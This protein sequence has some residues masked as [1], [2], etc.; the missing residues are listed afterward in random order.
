MPACP[1]GPTGWCCG[2]RA[3]AAE[4]VAEGRRGRCKG[5]SAARLFQRPAAVEASIASPRPDARRNPSP[6][7]G[8]FLVARSCSVVGPGRGDDVAA[9]A[10]ALLQH[11]RRPG[12]LDLVETC[13]GRGGTPDVSSGVVTRLRVLRDPLQDR[14]ER[15]VGVRS[16]PPAVN[17]P[18]S[19]P[20][21][22]RDGLREIGEGA[23]IAIQGLY[24]LAGR[25]RPGELRLEVGDG[26][27]DAA[28]ALLG[29]W[30]VS[31]TRGIQAVDEHQLGLDVFAGHAART[32]F[33][34]VVGS[35]HARCVAVML[36]WP[37]AVAPRGC[38]WSTMVPIF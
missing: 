38:S 37:Q 19:G 17:G 6:E 32:R 14:P 9:E 5:T 21:G 1:E 27:R 11:V 12:R 28:F 2:R 30:H 7:L 26:D 18:V 35:S 8:G 22:F 23:S 34:G 16:T 3:R 10:V 25:P 13:N 15:A 4:P 20:R 31:G 29:T 33:D 36:H 24:E